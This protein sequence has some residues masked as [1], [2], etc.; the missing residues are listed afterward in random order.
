MFDGGG[1]FKSRTVSH[2]RSHRS[3]VFILGDDEEEANRK[4]NL[5]HQQVVGT[6]CH[7][8]KPNDGPDIW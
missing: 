5:P 2:V 7:H 6:R 8:F 4:G 3:G 1:N